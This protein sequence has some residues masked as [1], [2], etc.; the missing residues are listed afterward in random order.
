MDVELVGS[1]GLDGVWDDWERLFGVDELATPFSAPGWGRAWLE[2]WSPGAEPW[3][4][5][6]R[7]GG[8]LA[9]IAPLVLRRDLPAR[10]LAM[11]G[12][13]PGDYWDVVAAPADREGVGLAVGAELVRLAGRWDA[14]I[15]NCFPPGSGTLDQFASVG[16]RI[17]RRAPVVSPR[18][19]LPESFEAY[20]SALPS[21]HRQNL[22]RHLRRLDSGEVGLRE[23]SDR[24]ELVEVMQRWRALRS[25]QWQARGR[26][27]SASH[28]KD[29]FHRFMLDAVSRLLDVGLAVVWEFSWKERVVG[30][31]VNFADERSFYWYLGGFDPDCAQLGLGKIAVGAAIRAS[32]S[33]GRRVFDFTRGEDAYK[34]WYGATDRHLSSVVIGHRRVRSRVAVGTAK[35]LSAYRARSLPSPTQQ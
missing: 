6:V 12:K 8:R 14:G 32:I 26:Q 11:I 5:R 29:H 25:L 34:Y 7:D 24:A 4:M 27:I 3:L 31:Y 10:V 33:A 21:S 35:L 16:L 19:E 15:L 23:I 22:R 9:G 1:A 28:E 18:V 20:L 13:D 30:V 2:H 17:F